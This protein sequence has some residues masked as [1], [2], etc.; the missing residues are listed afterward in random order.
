MKNDDYNVD[1]FLIFE[2]LGSF[3]GEPPPTPRKDLCKF[4]HLK[5]QPFVKCFH[6]IAVN[7]TAQVYLARDLHNT[8]HGGL[9][10]PGVEPFLRAIHGGG[11]HHIYYTASVPT[12]TNKF[13]QI[14]NGRA[15][16]KLRHFRKVDFN[17]AMSRVNPSV[18]GQCWNSQ[19]TWGIASMDFKQ[20]NQDEMVTRPTIKSAN[21]TDGILCQF[22]V[23]SDLLLEINKDNAFYCGMTAGND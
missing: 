19:Y 8:V 20:T 9:L 4:L 10:R 16:S 1:I 12:H 23:L 13:L 21:V 22:V 3:N 5:R 11:F 2:E 7:P 17:M 14:L 15:A 18:V 6:L